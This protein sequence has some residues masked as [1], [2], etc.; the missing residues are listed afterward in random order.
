MKKVGII[1]AGTMGKEI[2]AVFAGKAYDV[3]LMDKSQQVLDNAKG[4]ISGIVRFAKVFNKDRE[5]C[6]D[7]VTIG[8]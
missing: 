1:G 6:A 3:I 8:S 7:T 5:F 2:A 4:E